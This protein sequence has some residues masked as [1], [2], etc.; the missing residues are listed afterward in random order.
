MLLIFYEIITIPFKI[1]FDVNINDNWDHFVDTVFL[2]DI[3]ISF[4]TAYYSKGYPVITLLL[5]DMYLRFI[6]EKRL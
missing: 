2:F 6:I 4:N 3:V 5:N 1:S